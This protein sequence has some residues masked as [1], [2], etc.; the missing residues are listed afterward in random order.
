M[1]LKLNKA[2]VFLD[3][4]TTGL[5]VGSDRIVEISL[6]KVNTDNTEESLTRRVNPGM[7]IPLASSKIHGIYDKDVQDEASFK[8]L[9]PQLVKFIGNGDFAGFNSNKFDIP[10][11]VE[12]FLR[13]DVEFD[14]ESRK[15]V[16]VQNIFHFMEP[17]NLKAAYKFY[18]G[19]GLENAHSAEADVKATFEIFKAQLQ[20]YEGVQMENEKGE[21]VQPVV[22]DITRLAELSA[23]SRNVDLAGRIVFNEKGEEVFSFGKHKDKTVV[24]VFSKEPSYYNWMM[25]GDFPLYTKRVITRI[26]LGMKQ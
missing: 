17:R 10:V 8:D 15:L 25:Q 16:D 20:R 26:R 18:C 21:F 1:Q 4:E 22:N 23:K 24:E 5:N 9:A 14:L 7:P 3:L 12:E 6:L 2:L 13:A 11:L 19:K